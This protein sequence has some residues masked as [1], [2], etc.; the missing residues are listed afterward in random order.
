MSVI[1]SLSTE[2]SV[3]LPVVLAIE[4]KNI[5]K[6]AQLDLYYRDRAKLRVFL[7]Q[8]KLYTRF[9]RHQF[10]TKTDKVL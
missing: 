9:N 8:V 10:P 2:V 4:Y 1:G 7:T 3:T 6:I 5:S